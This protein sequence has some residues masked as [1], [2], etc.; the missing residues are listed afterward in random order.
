MTYI[1]GFSEELERLAPNEDD[2][3]DAIYIIELEIKQRVD[4]NFILLIKNM[5]A[6]IRYHYLKDTKYVENKTLTNQF[7][8][9]T[10]TIDKLLYKQ[11]NDIKFNRMLTPYLRK[12][13][14][15]GND[16]EFYNKHGE[17]YYL[18]NNVNN[19]LLTLL[20]IADEAMEDLKQRSKKD[21]D[22]Y[23][24]IEKVAVE[25]ARVLN[26]RNIDFNK[27]RDNLFE[28]CLRAILDVVPNDEINK[29]NVP[30]NLFKY[31][32][33]AVDNYKNAEEY[34]LLYIIQ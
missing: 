3:E 33:Y 32:K 11:L 17:H 22:I 10:I 31:V 26:Q 23:K 20:E 30:D 19:E 2:L 13:K 9:F 15:H 1:R 16:E 25:L 21:Y 5:V 34:S 8:S 14:L 6:L 29:F 4:G 7:K 28:N 24:I 18:L 27:S 12:R